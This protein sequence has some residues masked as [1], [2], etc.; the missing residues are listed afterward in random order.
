M[1][2]SSHGLTSRLD[3]VP[4]YGVQ[5]FFIM[6]R[7]NALTIGQVARE[8][9]VGVETVRFYEREGLITKP[10]KPANGGFRSYDNG[11]IDRIRFIRQAQEL[12]FSLGEVR[13]LLELRADP[14]AD[15]AE[16]RARATAKRADVE[17][18][19]RQLERIRDGLDALIAACPGR[20]ALRRCS[21]MDAFERP[22]ARNA[23]AVHRR[24]GARL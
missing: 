2:P 3:S 15:A 24:K 10:P 22:D 21:I 8:A 11:T 5:N 17:D 16:V 4:R 6:S 18:K 23:R 9:G 1:A 13:E 12:G 20:G 7:A 14:E 19:I